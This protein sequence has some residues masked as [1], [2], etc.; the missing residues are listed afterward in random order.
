MDYAGYSDVIEYG[1]SLEH[2]YTYHELLSGE[3][4]AAIYYDGIEDAPQAMW[5]TDKFLFPGCYNFSLASI[6]DLW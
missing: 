2:P 1:Y 6:T 4:A 3:W 5:L